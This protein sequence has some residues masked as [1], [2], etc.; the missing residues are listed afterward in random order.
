M[1]PI[2]GKRDE[3]SEGRHHPDRQCTE[4]W[5]YG[6]EREDRALGMMSVPMRLERGLA[7]GLR[8]TDASCR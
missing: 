7:Q 8:V 4:T 2:W 1:L 5:R 6:K 3:E